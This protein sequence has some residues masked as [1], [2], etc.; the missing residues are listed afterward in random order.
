MKSRELLEVDQSVVAPNT[1]K[2]YFNH[3]ISNRRSS[4][5]IK[6][7]TANMMESADLI[8]TVGKANKMHETSV[9]TNHFNSTDASNSKH[10]R[11]K[12]QKLG[13][14]QV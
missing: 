2:S 10:K 3:Y 11:S 8:R 1:A 14:T 7:G 12:T 13:G 4:K 5:R 6:H 9:T